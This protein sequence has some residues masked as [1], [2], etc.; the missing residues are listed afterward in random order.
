MRFPYAGYGLPGP[1]MS[2]I[3][4]GRGV[5]SRVGTQGPA[6]PLLARLWHEG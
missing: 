3:A 4:S 6:G 5:E 2:L 1:L